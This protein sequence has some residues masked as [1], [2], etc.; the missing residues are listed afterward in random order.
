[1]AIM[2]SRLDT[3]D[4]ALLC[5]G[6]VNAPTPAYS[7]AKTKLNF[8]FNDSQ[9][10]NLSRIAKFFTRQMALSR[11]RSSR[12]FSKGNDDMSIFYDTHDSANPQSHF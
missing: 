12:I 2:M 1:M 4:L 10:N 3:G 5:K 7:V 9:F 6:S 8:I 11:M